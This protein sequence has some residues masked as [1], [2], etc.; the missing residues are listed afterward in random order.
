LLQKCF[1]LLLQHA[2]SIPSTFLSHLPYISIIVC[3]HCFSPSKYLISILMLPYQIQELQYSDYAT[4][5]M[6]GVLGLDSLRRLGIFPFTASRMAL[7]L[8]HP[9]IQWV[10]GTLSLGVKRPGCESDHSLPSSA[11]VSK[12]LELYFHSPNTL[13]WR[14]AQL[15]K[16]GTG[17]TLLLPLPLPLPLLLPYLSSTPNISKWNVPNRSCKQNFVCSSSLNLPSSVILIILNKE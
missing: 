15:K 6:I 13:S 7:G 16:K 1:G 3:D 17:T 8:T 2:Y 5:S 12:C 11:E 9:P 14:G 4:G 10:P